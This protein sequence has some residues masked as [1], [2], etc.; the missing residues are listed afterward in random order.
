MTET[1]DSTKDVLETAHVREVVGVVH[2]RETLGTIVGRLTTAGFDRA[3]ID[4]MASQDTINRKFK[5]ASPDPADAADVPGV[6]RR[7]LITPSDKETFTAGLFGTL[8]SIGSL[9][10]ALPI[11]ASG[12]ALA[13]A[14]AAA[15][16]GGAV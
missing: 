13:A 1:R 4:L 3:D 16:A 5:T 6:P 7:E 15:A 8:M 12:G 14:V 11:V 10:A 2:S 9:G